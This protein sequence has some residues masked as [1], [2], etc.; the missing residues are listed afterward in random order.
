MRRAG[1]GMGGGNGKC[2]GPG[3]G[4]KVGANEKQRPRWVEC[5]GGKEAR[6]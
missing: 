4:T 5:G 2:K 6:K 3:V 1:W